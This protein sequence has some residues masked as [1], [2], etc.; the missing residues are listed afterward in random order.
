MTASKTHN[1]H[2]VAIPGVVYDFEKITGSLYASGADTRTAFPKLTAV[3][4]SLDAR[5]ADTRTAFP[6]LTAV[7][8]S[9]DARGADTSALKQTNAGAA[10]VNICRAALVASLELNGLVMEDGI[11]AKLVSKKGGVSRVK[12]VSR[13]KIVGQN[14][15]SYIIHRD[16]CTA[17][18]KTLAEARADLLL[19]LGDRDTTP[20][21]SWTKETTVSLEEMIVA[22]RTI[23]GACGQGVGHFLSSK[24]YRGKLSVAFVI[25]E[26][27]GRY[28][29]EAFKSFFEKK[30]VVR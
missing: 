3:G 7:G 1:G 21:K 9:L 14:K 12:S 13:V 15:I 6:K 18:G 17:H 16:G 11:L 26:T 30:E 22:Y 5:G 27:Q 19:K 8:G 2:L 10:A 25:E 28:G 4:G 23:T 29:H 20:F 24:N